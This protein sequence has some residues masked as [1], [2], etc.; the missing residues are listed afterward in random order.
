MADPAAG[1]A[2]FDSHCHLQA[3]YRPGDDDVP[4]DVPGLLAR[5]RAAG[6]HGTVCVGTDE[7]SSREALELARDKARPAADRP[8]LW[9]TVGLHP[10]EAST[11]VEGVAAL[12][13]A[14]AGDPAVV[15]VGECGLD[16]H[17]EH[18]P[19]AAQRDAFA[20]QLALAR[21]HDLAVVVHAREAWDDLFD[22]LAAEGAPE[23]GVLH[24]FTGG[25][26]EARRGLEAGFHLSFSGIA[27]FKNAPEVRAA[28]ALCPVDR[29]LVETDAPFLA[30]VPHRGRTNEPAL[31]AVVGTAVAQVRGVAPG[32]LAASSA[33]AAAAVF[34]LP[35]NWDN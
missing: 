14:V 29:L 19:R 17:Y 7:A 32:D 2:W 8:A 3:P 12:L 28:A 26:E 25:P 24:C 30:P 23:R 35:S 6:V 22:V 27:T 10:H 16:Y 4:A 20:A 13:A 9:A 34:A 5:A 15:A 31:V 33:R 1:P 21:E 11:G 18:S